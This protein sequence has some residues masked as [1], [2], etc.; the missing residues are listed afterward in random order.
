MY[1]GNF[2]AIMNELDLLCQLI[3]LC[4]AIFSENELKPVASELKEACFFKHLDDKAG[5]WQMNLPGA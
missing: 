3:P 4:R 2:T 1:S 5:C